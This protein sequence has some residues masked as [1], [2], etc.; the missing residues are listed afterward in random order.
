MNFQKK[1]FLQENWLQ[2]SSVQPWPTLGVQTFLETFLKFAP[3][4][5]G[6]KKTDGKWR[7]L[8]TKISQ[9]LSLKSSNMDPRHRDRIAFVRIVS[10]EFELE[11][12]SICLVL[13]DCQS[14][15]VTQFMAESREKN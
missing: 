2:S 15:H 1:L 6:H 14:F 9:G 3:E 8:M 7:I 12:V 10:G 11:W 5:H 4:P 13:E